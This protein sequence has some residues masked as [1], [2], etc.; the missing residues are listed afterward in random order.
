MEH[1]RSERDGLRS[2]QGRATADLTAM[3][4]LASLRDPSTY[5]AE[6]A[7]RLSSIRWNT[8]DWSDLTGNW[9]WREG[10]AIIDKLEGRGSLGER[11]SGTVEISSD[12]DGETTL[13]LEIADI[14]LNAWTSAI[15]PF[16]PSGAQAAARDVTDKLQGE[17]SA[18]IHLAVPSAQWQ[19]IDTWSG[20]GIIRSESFTTFGMNLKQTVVR[21]QLQQNSL[22]AFDFQSH[23]ENAIILGNAKI[24]FEAPFSFQV[25]LAL[26]DYEA[27]RLLES[28]GLTVPLEWE[29]RVEVSGDVKGELLPLVWSAEGEGRVRNLRV[30][31]VVI[32]S[33]IPF[34]LAVDAEETRL[35]VDHLPMWGG[36][37]TVAGH[38]PWAEHLASRLVVRLEGIDSSQMEQ[39]YFP[40]PEAPRGVFSGEFEVTSL[41][42]LD[43]FSALGELSSSEWEMGLLRIENLA[44]GLHVVDGEVQVKLQG[45]ALGGQLRLV[46]QSPLDLSELHPWERLDFQGTVTLENAR[47]EDAIRRMRREDA[48]RL[49]E[50]SGQLAGDWTVAWN[51]TDTFPQLRGRGVL[52]NV[53]WGREELLQ[54]AEGE[55]QLSG[56]TCEFR[57][58]SAQLGRGRITGQAELPLAGGRRGSFNLLATRIDLRRVLAPW[59]EVAREFEGTLD[60]RIRGQFDANWRGTADCQVS[61]ARYAGTE[62]RGLRLPV[63][64]SY[65]PERGRITARIRET[66]LRVAQGRA[67]VRGELHWGRELELQGLARLSSINLRT[68]L[69]GVTSSASVPNGRLDG[70]LEFSGSRIRSMNDLRGSFVGTLGDAQVLRL[71][72]MEA[73][74]PALGSGQLSASAFDS[75]DIQLSLARGEVEVDRLAFA[76]SAVQ[77]LV[78]GRATLEGRLDLDVMAHLGQI[79]TRT[80]LARALRAS[81]LVAAP[82]AQLA[83]LAQAN[84]WLTNRL[85]FLRVGGTFRSPSV[86]LRPA[87]TVGAEAVRFFLEGATGVPSGF[88]QP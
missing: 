68:L 6:G 30:P 86:Q 50:L 78:T 39:R 54:T 10:I 24:D 53:R 58:V 75:S 28:T 32:P 1:F 87:A 84:D 70:R 40:F 37:V 63:D 66:T 29:G 2:L 34:S 59:P 26:P 47:L 71:P 77:L 64:W 67:I 42:K 76:S 51:P 38:L 23:W 35:T 81:L 13:Q 48:E 61:R 36:M 60:S 62:V 55:L 43:S 88:P 7:F 17:A 5:R 82:P 69:R 33:E 46:G 16:L 18:E 45:N 21:W 79:N 73:I 14:P 20:E 57:N 85:I 3:V 8:L 19:D 22:D 83:L 72:V 31:D 25:A 80:P 52:R 15:V 41:E 9:E 11:L 49:R 56:T 4:S 74:V 27:S 12:L 44:A 65:S